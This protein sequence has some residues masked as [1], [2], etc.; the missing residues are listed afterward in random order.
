M[1]GRS[2][3]SRQ[4]HWA[5]VVVVHRAAEQVPAKTRRGRVQV[6]EQTVKQLEYI[7]ARDE[8]EAEEQQ[9][10]DAAGSFK[11]QQKEEA[12]FE[13]KQWRKQ[14]PSVLDKWENDMEAVR[15]DTQ[16]RKLW[17]DLKDKSGKYRRYRGKQIAQKEAEIKF[18][19]GFPVED[20]E[21]DAEG[22]AQDKKWLDM[23]R[24]AWPS[25]EALDPH[26][27]ESFGFGLVGEVTGAH[28]IHGDVRVRA[29]DM[30][31]DQ[32]WEPEE[33]FSRRNYSN[34]TEPS[35]RVHL[36]APQ[37]RFPRPFKII[38]GKRVQRRVFALRLKGVDSVEDAMALRGYKVYALEPPPGEKKESKKGRAK[39]SEDFGGL[40][41][42]DADT[43]HFHLH[44]ALELIGS[45]CLMI[46]GEPSDEVLAEFAY[47]D[48]PDAAREVLSANSFEALPFGD[49]SGVVPDFKIAPRFRCRQA[50][51]SLL[52]ITLRSEVSGGEGRFLYEPDPES[53]KGK[54]FNL[55]PPPGG[56]ERVVYV[57]FVPDMIARVDAD[58]GRSSV[59]FTLP[60]GHIEA[61][62]FTCRK[63]VLDE[64]GLL[65]IP[66][67]PTVKG[68][69]PPSGKSHAVRRQDGKR[70]PLHGTAPAPPEDM[71]QPAGMIF[72]EPPDRKSVV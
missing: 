59:Y 18:N 71:L 27:P 37:R 14:N 58:R 53:P 68:L 31:C 54:F 29:D 69:L 11:L 41:L 70:R 52:D 15:M 32:G 61:T 2:R 36:K 67:G 17:G 24:A 63:R 42:Y 19:R 12:F 40:D 30:L 8:M 28:G 48:T 45:Q 60:K 50:A 20:P 56:Y 35:K 4:L 26:D 38:T 39:D 33:Y 55:M 13:R 21:D 22:E 1:A 10:L 5:R 25:Q 44:D 6:A 62:S 3:R 47:A 51:H 46:M 34:W 43:T 23:W 49:I 66:R 16:R 72:P 7:P 64:K 65:A 57:P 9:L